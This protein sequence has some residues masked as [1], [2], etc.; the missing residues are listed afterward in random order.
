MYPPNVR[1]SIP[2]RH[3]YLLLSSEPKFSIVQIRMNNKWKI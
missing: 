3:L 1:I 2:S